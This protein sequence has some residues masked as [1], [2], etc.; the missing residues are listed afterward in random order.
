MPEINKQRP[1]FLDPLIIHLPLP[2][3]L[4]IM[5]RISG[6]GMFLILP[7]LIYLLQLSLG[8][9]QD[10]EV[11]RAITHHPLVKLVLLVL[12]YGFLHHF[13]MGVRIL[14]IDMHKGVKI[15]AARKSAKVVLFAS[16]TLAVILGVTLW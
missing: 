12:L 7:C 4:S 2:G 16:I 5:H 8:S 9:P 15:E 14:L 11:F 10:F 13:F 6:A 3:K 1:K